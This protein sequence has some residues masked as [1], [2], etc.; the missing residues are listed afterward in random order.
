M[1]K[2]RKAVFYLIFISMILSAL[3]ILFIGLGTALILLTVIG[4][5]GII[6]LK[7]KHRGLFHNYFFVL[8]IASPLLAI[9]WLLFVLAFSCSASHIAVDRIYS[10]KDRKV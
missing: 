4:I 10:R 2:L 1:G 8:A 7:S 5:S 6:I 3:I 9:H